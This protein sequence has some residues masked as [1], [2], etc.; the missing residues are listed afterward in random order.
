MKGLSK[1]ISQADDI[2]LPVVASAAIT[3]VGVAN[4]RTI[5][6]VFVSPDEKNIINN[7]I[8]MHE[9]IQEGNCLSTWGLTHD[10]K[11]VILSL[12]F[13]NPISQKVFV[14]FE[15]IKFGIVVEQIMY[16]QCTFLTVGN[17]NSKLSSSMDQKRILIDLDC[18]D[19][20]DIWSKTFKEV[21]SKHLRKKHNMSKKQSF[22]IF[23]KMLQEWDIFKKLRL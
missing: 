18:D 23:D 9:T 11:Y 10:K 14:F 20:K 1:H 19:F 12:D 3:C 2:R 7:I 4:G 13:Q 8:D 21:Y 6:V 17:E 22:R 15:I 5:P 16:S